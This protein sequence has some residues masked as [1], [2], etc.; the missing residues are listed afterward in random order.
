MRR[1]RGRATQGLLIGLLWLA[2]LATGTPGANAGVRSSSCPA[3]ATAIAPGAVIQEAVDRAGDNA[4]LCLKNGVHRAQAIRPRSGQHFYGEGQTVLNGSRLLTGFRRE[5]EYWVT[6]VQLPVYPKHGECLPSAPF[7]NHPEAV[8]LDDRPLTRVSSKAEL[9]SDK[10]YI[11]HTDRMLYLADDPT[12]RMVEVA[13]A[14]FAFESAAADVSISNIIVEKFA[15]A[16]QKGA[17]HAT[18]G[19]RWTIENCEVRLNSGAGIGLGSGGHA[20]NCDVHSNGQ[21]GIAGHGRDIRIEHNHIWSNNI[22]GFDG[23]WEAGGAKIALSDGVTFR[24][25]H[26]HD[27][28]GPGLWCDIDCRHVLYENNLVERNRDI[29]IFHEISFD[30]V[31]RNNVVR[32]NGL[33]DRGWFWVSDIVLAASQDVEVLDNKITVARGRCGIMLIDQGRRDNGKRYKT[34]NNTVLAN[35]MTFDGPACAGGVSDTKPGNDNFAIITEGNNLFEGNTY[36]VSQPVLR[37]R[38][39]WGHDVIGWN[40]FRRRGQ[41]RSG[42]LVPFQ[43]GTQ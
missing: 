21:I 4:L 7:C 35:E 13:V 23:T 32:N 36:R 1:T 33:G 41:E 25:N 22:Y 28:N 17:I 19:T 16:A 2:S 40:G 42:Q 29:G 39:V 8:F 27:N 12:N 3:D 26:V 10:F 38:F 34:R 6:G 11:D 43:P 9:A 5:G 15:N 14:R 30:A 18:E 24:G 31:I 20:G 37:A